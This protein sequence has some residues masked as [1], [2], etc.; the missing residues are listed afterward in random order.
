MT[1]H[2]KQRNSE[3]IEKDINQSRERLDTTLNEIEE[4]FSPQQLLNTSYE[5]LRHG[6][7][8]EFMANLGTTIKQ[9]P[10][11]FL[12]TTAG[13][14]WMML[15][16]RQPNRGQHQ[17]A[18]DTD[19]RFYT[20]GQYSS[21]TPSNT[22]SA[23]GSVG[24]PVHEGTHPNAAM[25]AQ[26]A[27]AGGTEHSSDGQGRMSEMSHKAKDSAQHLG[28]KAKQTAQQWGDKA[29]HL[30][31]NMRDSTSHLQHGAHDNLHT[32]GQR[33]RQ[34]ESQAS[35]FIQEHPLVVGALGFALG[36]AL[37]GIFPATKKE[38]EYMG[39][40]RDR[41]LHKAAETGQEQM[42]KAQHSIHE[43]AESYKGE[44]QQDKDT[45]ASGS[46]S[47][48]TNVNAPQDRETGL[49]DSPTPF[50][51][52]SGDA[53]KNRSEQNSPE[54]HSPGLAGSSTPSGNTQGSGTNRTP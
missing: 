46:S 35:D 32:M 42:D 16:Q 22:S 31:D 36:A 5:Y 50:A 29:H 9:N 28:Q 15:S 17:F 43:K 18:S 24:I 34:A 33:A 40:Y 44:S 47:S 21:N 2:D 25:H 38:D 41:V 26:P 49:K 27:G 54:R 1:D 14:G 10:L 13:L 12:V 45:Q 11:P 7:A 53:E 20:G 52:R 37:G 6:G 39:E 48:G 4:R 30:G 19:Q 51:E 8:N 3:E 23:P